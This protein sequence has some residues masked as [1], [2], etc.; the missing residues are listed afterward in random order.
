MPFSGR[1]SAP[2]A[3]LVGYVAHLVGYVAHLVRYI[4]HVSE[5]AEDAGF[6]P[7]TVLLSKY[8]V[9]RELGV[10]GMSRV[11]E[12]EHI[13]LGTKVA[14]KVL[15]P[16]LARLPDAPAR[17]ER[18]ALAS[19]RI[20]SD[21]IVRVTD[22]GV[23]PSPGPGAGEPYMVME[24]LEGSDLG[25]LVKA[26]KRFGIEEAID[27]VTQAAD[28]L[29]R[30]HDAGVVHRDVK[31]SNLFLT[32]RPDGAPLVKVLDF[33]ISKL[34]E[35]AATENLQLTKT[36][37]V[38]GSAMYMSIEQMRSPK[39]VDRRTDVWAL[40]VSLYELLSGTHP[41]KA[42]S[43]TE[44]CVKVSLDPPDPLQNHRP[45]VPDALAAAI[46]IA[47]ARPQEERY[48]TVGQLVAAL[49]PFASEETR[50]HIRAIRSFE[51]RSHPDLADPVRPSRP[52]R[53]GVALYAVLAGAA[54]AGV[55][56]LAWKWQPGLAATH[57]A[58]IAGGQ[59]SSVAP[60]ASAEN[61]ARPVPT[62]DASSEPEVDSGVIQAVADAGA[63]DAGA[64]PRGP[65]AGKRPTDQVILPNGMR[66]PCSMLRR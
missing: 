3:H 25:R 32:T 33:G 11:L 37:A 45:D 9:I 6:P 7:G 14:V 56:A 12:A 63:V 24:Y 54:L 18:E 20:V 2:L 30:A 5:S 59:P 53:L 36:T 42:E 46:A 41:W 61:S 34:V 60:S 23:L 15:L 57:D 17:F 64:R 50:R 39:T 28:A 38:M 10:G 13:A 26:G 29:S 21:H 16:E 8:R 48:Q 66:V 49:D 44:L 52:P 51:R 22:V 58:G 1:A 55:A 40:G 35:E 47:Y 19:T 43:F 31:P 27:F 62:V 65:C 4:A